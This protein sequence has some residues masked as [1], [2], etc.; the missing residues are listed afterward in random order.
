MLK[1]T[2]WNA[3][4]ATLSGSF[5]NRNAGY[6]CENACVQKIHSCYV[7]DAPCTTLHDQLLNKPDPASAGTRAVGSRIAYFRKLFVNS[8]HVFANARKA[9]AAASAT[10][11]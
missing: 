11:Y 8:T 2:C 10:K 1:P 4:R 6:R 7:Y 3:Q 5:R 9:V